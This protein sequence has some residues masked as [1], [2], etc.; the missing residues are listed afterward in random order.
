M[1]RRE[2]IAAA[3]I[4]GIT[5]LAGCSQIESLL[6][7]GGGREFG[8]TATYEGVEAI[9]TKYVLA[10]TVTRQFERTEETVS[11][12]SGAT[13]IL[14][15]LRISHEG[16]SAVRFPE[17][18]RGSDSIYVRH[19]GNPIPSVGMPV[20]ADSLTVEGT[21]LQTY[22]DS[23]SENVTDEGYPGT[24]VSGWFMNEVAANF[25]PSDLELHVIWNEQTVGDEGEVEQTWAYTNEAEVP[26]NELQGEGT[27]VSI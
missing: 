17:N 23:L 10:E 22:S 15:H 18:R 6:G 20:P 9:P 8:D 1:R 4:T 19:D 12:A 24:E 2:F 26:V 13:L 27:T 14:T 7:T 5:G 16:D 3:G 21:N 25:T 11:A